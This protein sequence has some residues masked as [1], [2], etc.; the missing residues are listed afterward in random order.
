VLGHGEV[1][2]DKIEHFKAEEVLKYYELT[3]WKGESSEVKREF[4]PR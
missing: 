3:N 2:P 1:K 4:K